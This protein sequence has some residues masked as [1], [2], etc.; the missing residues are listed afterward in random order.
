VQRSK[1]DDVTVAVDGVDD[2]IRSRG[3]YLRD[4]VADIY[5]ARWLK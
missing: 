1:K 3:N 5:T 4:R 2:E